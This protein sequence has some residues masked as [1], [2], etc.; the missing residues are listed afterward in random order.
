MARRAG[1]HEADVMLQTSTEFNVQVRKGEIETLTQSGSKGLGLRVFV[2]G[3]M[4]FAATSD[5]DAAVLERLVTSTVAL[6]ASA[7]PKPENGLPDA[8][9]PEPKPE[10]KIYDPSIESLPT[11]QKIGM[12]LRCEAAAFSAD[13]RITN[14]EGAGLGSGATYTLLANSR[15]VSASYRSSGCSVY[16]QPLA[17]EDGKKQVDYEYSFTRSLDRLDDPEEVGRKAAMRVVRKL[18][19]R[20][21]P[22]QSA[23]V[24]FDRRIAAQIWAG[25]MAALNGD[26]VY[27]EMSFL[28][29]KLGR[30]IAAES[31][32][33][34]DDGTL[35]GGAGSAP[36][37]GEGIPTRRNVLIEQGVLRMFL[38][39]TET[40][41]KVGGG[42]A[43][44]ANA[45]RSYNSSPSIGPLNLFLLA[46]SLTP[47]EIVAAIPNGFLVT[48]MMGAGVNPVTGDFSTGASGLWIENGTLAYP[49]E[50]VTIAGS[51]ATL[52]NGIERIGSDLIFNSSV[53]SPTVQVAEMV[54]SGS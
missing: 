29:D 17:E 22:T 52:L 41:R 13:P 16:C 10:L 8:P 47:E 53:A 36:F 7:D 24:V 54:V 23:P 25:V 34:I 48:N 21:V 6:A 5:F 50:E 39:D 28:K 37:D 31:V 35:V 44:T 43:S 15:G 51:M 33:L 1:A 14:S 46:G 26:M 49:V 38:Y 40:A 2:D 19:A 27:K 12:A 4:G 3:R 11:D 32:T 20:K 45:R 9:A 42:A 18:G 30:K